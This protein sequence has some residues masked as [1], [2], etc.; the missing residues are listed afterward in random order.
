MYMSTE[1]RGSPGGKGGIKQPDVPALQEEYTL[2]MAEISPFS[3]SFSI[4]LKTCEDENFVFPY[5]TRNAKYV[6]P[7]LPQ[8]S[9]YQ[10]LS[11]E[12][13]VILGMRMLFCPK[14]AA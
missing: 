1:G 7:P 9:I 12:L 3:S 10:C 4:K 2:L 6:T 13:C 14:K 11:S 8:T 5:I